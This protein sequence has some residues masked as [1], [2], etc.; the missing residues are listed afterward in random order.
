MA[1]PMVADSVSDPATSSGGGPSVVAK[2]LR[3]DIGHHE[4]GRGDD[5]CQRRMLQPIP[6]EAA[7]E[8]RPGPEA[9]REQEQ[10]EEAL[11]DLVRQRDAEL[12]HDYAGEQ[13]A[14]HGAEL[15]AAKRDLPSRYPSPSTRKNAIS[16]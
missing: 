8:L 11:L 13:R 2:G 14:R 6:L 7:E 1:V 3:D 9:D 5:R 12:P 15:E 4:P 16:G 10:Q